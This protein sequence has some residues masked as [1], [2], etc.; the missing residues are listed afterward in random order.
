M[1][2]TQTYLCTTQQISMHRTQTYEPTHRAGHTL[3]LVITGTDTGVSNLRVGGFVSDHAL[4]RFTLPAKMS[5]TVP[6]LVGRRSWRR[7]SHDAFTADLATSRLCAR[8]SELSDLSADE[9]AQL[10]DQVMTDLLDQHCPVVFVRHRSR[11]TTP[12]FDADCRAARRR[13]RAA[14]RRFRR[15]RTEVN[16][17]AWIVKLKALRVLYEEK[18][19]SYWR[20][21]IAAS[22]GN[23]K[24]LWRT[25]NSALGDVSTSETGGLS[26]DY[27]LLPF[28]IQE[29]S[30]SSAAKE[31]GA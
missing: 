20:S 14:E 31:G 13:V 5:P 22:S 21:E 10:Y 2:R 7:L 19:S 29:C 6:P 8:L 26:A 16:K 23:S 15:K 24:K 18:N 3:D 11:P 25:F 9:L 4:I 12:W 30:G 27:R 28:C 1:H 17:R